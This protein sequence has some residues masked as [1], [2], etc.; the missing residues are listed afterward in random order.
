MDAGDGSATVAQ[1]QCFGDVGAGHTGAAGIDLV[2]L[3]HIARHARLPVVVHVHG[4]RQLAQAVRDAL[5]YPLQHLL[6]RSCHAVGHHARLG[7]AQRESLRFGAHVG[8]GRQSVAAHTVDHGVDVSAWFHADR[9]VGDIGCRQGGRQAEHDARAAIGHVADAVDHL[10]IGF[11]VAQ[12][13]TQGAHRLQRHA[14]VHARLQGHRDLELQP[15]GARQEI[16]RYRRQHRHRAGQ[17]Q[18]HGAD[19]QQL[20]VQERGDHG[21]VATVEAGVVVFRTG[22]QRLH[23]R[24]VET[25]QRRDRDAEQPG[26]KQGHGQHDS[27]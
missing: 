23:L 27:Q 13:G 11:A 16:V 18:G 7:R 14:R 5:G 1:L 15:V 9:E 24:K 19:E 3:D 22:V 10:G 20:M 2:H 26:A 8:H 21:A 17:C 4:T 25:Q 12:P 6:I